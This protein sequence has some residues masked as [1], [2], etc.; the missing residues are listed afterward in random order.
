MC[1]VHFEEDPRP[2]RVIQLKNILVIALQSD[3]L[4]SVHSTHF[5]EIVDAQYAIL[6]DSAHSSD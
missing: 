2:K 4:R 3:S 1:T 6:R 5:V